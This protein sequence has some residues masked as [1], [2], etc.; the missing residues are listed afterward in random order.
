MADY[1]DS[2]CHLADPRIFSDVEA[3]LVRSRAQ[4][5]KG[6]VQGGVDPE[7]WVRQEDLKQR[8]PGEI[9]TSFGLHPWWVARVSREE[10][11][12]GFSKL[13]HALPG[14]DALGEI[15]L[16]YGPKLEKSSYENQHH[17]FR[18]QLGLLQITA[19]P[20]VL[21]IVRAHSDATS[22]L[23]EF[24]PFARE[25]I[26]HSFSGT[27]ENARKYLDLGL[28]L[29]ISG[30]ITRKGFESLKKAVR[31][32]PLDRLLVETDSPDQPLEGQTLNEPTSLIE[33][34][35]VI[36]ELRENESAENVLRTSAT[37]VARIFRAHF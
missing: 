37:N 27:R 21:H 36:A 8:F 26:V 33:I 4:G 29:S 32:I 7:D 16:D 22:T 1:V 10:F 14:A 17:A 5:I 18:R 23:R 34:A 19:K 2:H 15:G 35:K 12:A 13:A 3:V 25:G 20:L 11:E 6:W 9:L 30:G 24:G 28:S 31:Y